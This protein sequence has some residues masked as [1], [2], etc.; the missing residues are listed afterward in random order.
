MANNAEQATK[1]VTKF[2]SDTMKIPPLVHLQKMV[3]NPM[4]QKT[5]PPVV[6]QDPAALSQGDF[7]VYAN[8]PMVSY[9][10][11]SGPTVTQ[12]KCLSSTAGIPTR[13]S[14]CDVENLNVLKFQT[15][16]AVLLR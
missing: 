2:E 12:A 9:R 1:V 15:G 10:S 16:D 5:G 7:S 13:E 3:D 14:T 8:P 11:M 4:W 6:L